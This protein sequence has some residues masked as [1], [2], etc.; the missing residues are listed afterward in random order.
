[1]DTLQIEEEN[2][3]SIRHRFLELENGLNA[4]KVTQVLLN[5]LSPQFNIMSM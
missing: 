2:L 4:L 5:H 3:I 1:M